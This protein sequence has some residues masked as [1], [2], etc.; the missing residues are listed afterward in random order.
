M[1][2][3]RD[4]ASTTPSFH[5]ST[6]V[7]LCVHG[8][9]RA[10]PYS[11]IHLVRLCVRGVNAYIPRRAPP[12]FDLPSF[13]LPPCSLDEP[14]EQ[15]RTKEG[16]CRSRGGENKLISLTQPAVTPPQH[17]INPKP[18]LSLFKLYES[19]RLRR[20]IGGTSRRLLLL[21]LPSFPLLSIF[22]HSVFSLHGLPVSIP[23]DRK[24]ITRILLRS[25]SQRI[26]FFQ[27]NKQKSA[28]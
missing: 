1:S 17:D 14:P 25:S 26:D 19:L 16:W 8:T 20:R 9:R 4:R 12:C 7:S 13:S 3:R 24:K 18:R 22:W 10:Y 2:L 27:S 28:I 6:N 11:Y 23:W 21:L 5:L 15:R